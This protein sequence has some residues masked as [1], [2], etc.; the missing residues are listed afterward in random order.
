LFFQAKQV[1]QLCFN[2]FGRLSICVH[3]AVACGWFFLAPS[4]DIESTGETDHTEN[5]AYDCRYRPQA[6]N[7]WTG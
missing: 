2:P 5:Q 4:P 3:A 6:A 7:C 1:T